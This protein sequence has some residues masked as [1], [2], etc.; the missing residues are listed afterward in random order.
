[1][2]YSSPNTRIRD[3]H[4]R[5]VVVKL[6]Y[7]Y[8]TNPRI[9]IVQVEDFSRDASRIF[10]PLQYERYGIL[11]TVVNF[12]FQGDKNRGMAG[13]GRYTSKKR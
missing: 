11:K 5:K 10:R 9:F 7:F 13:R 6:I 3:V 8:K 12:W 2:Y 1:M 4:K